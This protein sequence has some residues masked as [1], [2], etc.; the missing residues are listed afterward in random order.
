MIKKL[1]ELGKVWKNKHHIVIKVYH[2]SNIPSVQLQGDKSP[3][4]S[5][6]SHLPNLH[7]VLFFLL[8]SSRPQEEFRDAKIWVVEF[9]QLRLPPFSSQVRQS[10]SWPI[11]LSLYSPHQ[12]F[13]S[14]FLLKPV[15]FSS[16][17]SWAHSLLIIHFV[18]IWNSDVKKTEVGIKYRSLSKSLW[19][20]RE[21]KEV[22]ECFVHWWGGNNLKS[23][24]MEWKWRQ[25][26][27]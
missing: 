18:N 7:I 27:S 9:I 4:T 12:D 2:F 1:K 10:S 25:K 13:L 8:F 3:Q 15:F 11:Y 26:M 17:S 6:S 14:M 22:G 19:N 5:A 20:W 16:L 23:K 21:K 24:Q